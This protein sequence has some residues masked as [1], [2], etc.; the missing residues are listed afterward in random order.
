MLLGQ[1]AGGGQLSSAHDCTAMAVTARVVAVVLASA[2]SKPPASCQPDLNW[3]RQLQECLQESQD[4]DFQ[5]SAWCAC[6]ALLQLC[7]AAHVPLPAEVL[8]LLP[9]DR[10][11]TIMYCKKG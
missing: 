8:I 4:A 1:A 11:M 2:T 6:E 5:F 3:L 10:K 9:I 7:L